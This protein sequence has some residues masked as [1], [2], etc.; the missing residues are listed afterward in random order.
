M[1]TSLL[2]TLPTANHPLTKGGFGIGFATPDGGL[3]QVSVDG[4]RIGGVKA[5]LTNAQHEPVFGRSYSLFAPRAIRE[6]TSQLNDAVNELLNAPQAASDAHSGAANIGILAT[7]TGPPFDSRYGT[8]HQLL[9][10]NP[11]D[12]AVRDAAANVNTLIHE[13]Y[14]REERN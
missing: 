2:P 3:A 5:S 6:A 7:Y 9:A 14:D 8:N 10:G 11:Y 4:Y 12:E 13:R 1:N